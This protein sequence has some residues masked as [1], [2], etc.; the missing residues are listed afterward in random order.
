[1]MLIVLNYT[2]EGLKKLPLR[3]IVALAARCAR[4]VESLSLLP[5]GHPDR[6]RCR[7]AIDGAI[8][9][10]EDFARG[11]PCRAVRSVIRE[12]EACRAI[13]QGEYVRETAAAAAVWTAH[14]AATALESLGMHDEPAEVDVMG[15]C[16]PNPFPHLSNVTADLA[17]REAFTADVDAAGA[18]GH[19]DK[20]IKGADQDYQAVIDLE[21][22][23]YPEAGRP[24]D[25]SPGGPLGGL[26]AAITTF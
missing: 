5:D 1:M 15:T 23:R 8:R 17:A 10:A 3:A 11:S 4:R 16:Q 6:D 26:W 14:A 25:P 19:A 24:I 13:A 7:A 22:G 2:T 18:A 12:V 9:L 20:F 21:L